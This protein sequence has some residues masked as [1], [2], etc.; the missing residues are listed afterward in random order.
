MQSQVDELQKTFTELLSSISP[1][2]QRKA[3]NSAM[4]KEANNLKKAA[5]RNVR[6]SPPSSKKRSRE[7][8][9]SNVY[10]GVYS[11]VYP[12]RYG[13]GFMV[14][15][16]PHGSKGIHTNKRGKQKPVLMFAEEGTEERNVGARRGGYAWA[17]GMFA[18][19]SWRK[20]NRSGHSTGSMP[21]YQ[22]LQRAYE[23]EA[24]GI[25]QRLWTQFENNVQR[26][27]DNIK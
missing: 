3:L 22:F 5:W 17:K 15:V 12:K 6:S 2:E 21:K 23:S 9:T 26:A 10:K 14:T 11:R 25:E 27:A 13:A 1:A 8:A 16:K 7:M 19:K 18:R 24:Q 4:R 20:Y